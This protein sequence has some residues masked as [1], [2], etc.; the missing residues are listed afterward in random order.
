MSI[1][2]LDMPN[3]RNNNNNN[4]NKSDTNKILHN[5]D[6]KHRDR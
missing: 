5:K 1:A 3:P 6:I 2:G 4:N